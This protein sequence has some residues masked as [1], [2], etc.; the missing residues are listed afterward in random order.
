MGRSRLERGF[1]TQAFCVFEAAFQQFISTILNP[2]RDIGVSRAPVWRVV[3]K[4]TILGG[5][6]RRRDHNPIGKLICST[7]VVAENGTG[8][9]RGR[10]KTI[11]ILNDGLDPMSGQDFQCRSLGWG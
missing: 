7:S 8:N 4:P 1:V 6:M 2:S 5:I 10:G 3:F 11:S 9:C